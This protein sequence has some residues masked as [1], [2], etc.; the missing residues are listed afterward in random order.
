MM[1]CPYGQNFDSHRLG[2]NLVHVPYI[3]AAHAMDGIRRSNLCSLTSKMP[4]SG[5]SGSSIA[6]S[7]IYPPC[8]ACFRRR[9]PVHPDPV[10]CRCETRNNAVY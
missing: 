10:K 3:T 8:R 5:F 2:D 1:T 6:M 9:S 7:A 4:L